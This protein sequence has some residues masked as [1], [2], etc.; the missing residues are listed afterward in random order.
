MNIVYHD[1]AMNV[2]QKM[3]DESVAL[4]A[5][6]PP[7]N[8]GHTQQLKSVKSIRSSVVAPGDKEK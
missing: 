7:F 4:C 5:L 2:L 3:S 6:D 1:D 8:T